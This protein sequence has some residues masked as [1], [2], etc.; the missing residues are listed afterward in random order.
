MV[1]AKVT[2]TMLVSEIAAI[3]NP[4]PMNIMYKPFI[5]ESPLLTVR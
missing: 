5:L 2:F 3:I 4:S 1:Q